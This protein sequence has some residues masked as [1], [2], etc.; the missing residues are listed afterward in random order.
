MDEKS[1]EQKGASASSS[2]GHVPPA[3]RQQ[4][5]IVITVPFPTVTATRNGS[6]FDDTAVIIRLDPKFASRAK[7]CASAGSRNKL[8]ALRTLASLAAFETAQ[9]NEADSIVLRPS[10]GILVGNNEILVGFPNATSCLY[11]TNR[12]T[13]LKKPFKQATRPMRKVVVHPVT[14]SSTEEGF[15]A[16]ISTETGCPESL[17]TVKRGVCAENPLVLSSFVTITLPLQFV[18]RL[19]SVPFT[20]A[21]IPA[22]PRD[23]RDP[24]PPPAT[25][26]PTFELMMPGKIK[27]CG[28]CFSRDHSSKWCPNKELCA[29]CCSS[30]H[31]FAKCD[32]K[33]ECAFCKQ[34]HRAT[35][36]PLYVQQ[37]KRLQPLP[38]LSSRRGAGK[39]SPPSPA[40]APSAP[41]TPASPSVPDA[42]LGVIQSL[43][44]TV[45]TLSEE[46]RR[47]SAIVAKLQA[48][49]S[50]A[51]S[52]SSLPSPSAL[53]P[54]Q[55]QQQPAS[56]SQSV[57]GDS[58]KQQQ[59]PLLKQDKPP[60]PSSSS[61]APSPGLAAGF[62]NSKPRTRAAR[63]KAAA[64]AS[65][66]AEKKSGT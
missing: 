59:Q 6:P 47:L 42:A 7:Q 20:A 50:P 45:A 57:S 40:P 46:V 18:T 36:C 21:F 27:A 30:S 37:R 17:L 53:M 26:R 15:R 54:S 19:R 65:G 8:D 23:P 12:L 16:L 3:D 38:L 29:G 10:R 64:A 41:S 35:R 34:A 48:A 25:I 32:G 58:K 4:T 14:D 60:A 9:V 56:Y 55:Q 43:T 5:P 1:R 44:H 66:T 31:R 52:P 33:L 11:F 2:P 13:E 22:V 28:K 49:Q 39:K 61:S 62:L 24:R 63:N 51:P